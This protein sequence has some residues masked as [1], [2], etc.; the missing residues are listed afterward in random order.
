MLYLLF[1]HPIELATLMHKLWNTI[2][3][4]RVTEAMLDVSVSR[5]SWCRPRRAR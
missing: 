4:N 2:F 3:Y 1:K 5:D